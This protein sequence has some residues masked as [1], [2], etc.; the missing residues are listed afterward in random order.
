[1]RRAVG[2]P[3]FTDA[4]RATAPADHHLCQYSKAEK[5]GTEEIQTHSR[6]VS[7]RRKLTAR[8]TAFIHFLIIT[9]SPLCCRT[10]SDLPEFEQIEDGAF[11]NLTKLRTM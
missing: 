9:R 4:Q 11:A 8:K 6:L 7:K 1:M 3:D 10:M 5:N 2:Y